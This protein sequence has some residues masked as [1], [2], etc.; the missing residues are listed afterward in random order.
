[1]MRKTK[2][3]GFAIDNRKMAKNTV[4]LYVRT[5]I[6]MVISFFTAR[7]TL[8]ILGSEDYG[9]NNLVGSIV[10]LFSFLNA[11][12]GTAVQRFFNYEMGKGN[13]KELGKVYGVGVYLHILVAFV[14]FI[15]CEVFAI[16]FLHK[17]NIPAERLFAA[18][19]VFQVS[20]ISMVFQIINVPNYALLKA[21]EEFS[22]I[23]IIEI[24]QAVLR[25]VVLYFLYTISYDKLIV[26]ATFNFGVT[27]YYVISLFVSARR[28]QESHH[29]ICRDKELIKQM[30]NFI[31]LLLITVLA[32]FGRNQGLVMLVNL[33]FGLTIN[34]AFA[35]A[36]QVSHMVNTFIINIKQPMVPQLMGSYGADDKE[37]ML[38]IIYKGTKITCVLLLMISLPMMFEMTSLLDI[39]LKNPPDNADKISVLFLIN[40]NIA[41]FT[42]FL[43]QG[44]HATGKIT[45]QQLIMSSLYVL[46]VTLIYIAFKM[47]MDYYSSLYLTIVISLGQC[48]ANVIL[49]KKYF[50]LNVHEF[51][52]KC[53][54]PCLVVVTITIPVLW[55][56]V[57]F[58]PISLWRVLV[59]L[60]VGMSLILLLGY[61]IVMDY[62]EKQV[63][64]MYLTK[65]L[66]HKK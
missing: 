18:H 1:M 15:L 30:L 56:I 10:S 55:G 58:L 64:R 14:T 49:A 37:A 23:A 33:F 24:I 38:D 32:E 39:W 4:A 9:L 48:M 52:Q 3:M 25:L 62:N 65:V 11:S 40:A 19:I 46:N 50:N 60:L 27:L 63:I 45:N 28:Y 35:I 66:I 21:H 42:Y 34:A 2:G 5:G 43:Y 17:M 59:V 54:L 12:M 8:E 44:V 13:S 22:R 6:T 41:S 47:G 26:F 57:S 51:L 36:T 16:F 29:S 53:L 31:S 61:I 20:I 7:I